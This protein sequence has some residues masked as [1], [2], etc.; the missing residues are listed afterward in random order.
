RFIIA[1]LLSKQRGSGWGYKPVTESMGPAELSCPLSYLDEVPVADSKFAAPWRAKVR[2]HHAEKRR[3]QRAVAK[4]AIGDRIT[5]VAGCQHHT[6]VMASRK[7]LIGR[8]D[9]GSLWRIPRRVIES[10]QHAPA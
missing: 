6:L 9:D 3:I 2:R 5:L 7:P 4:A 10:I 8:A 1:Y